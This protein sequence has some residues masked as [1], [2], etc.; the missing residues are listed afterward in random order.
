MP[1]TYARLMLRQWGTTPERAAALQMQGEP[2]KQAVVDI[3]DQFRQLTVLDRLL[4][5]GWGLQ[6][7]A[8]FDA[9]SH[10]QVGVAM[11]CAPNF[12]EALSVA[13]RFGH[14]R[15]PF[16]RYEFRVRG[17]YCDLVMHDTGLLEHTMSVPLFDASLVG[18]QNLLKK[19][20]GASFSGV[21]FE[22]RNERPSYAAR[23]DDYLDA[24]V[25]FGAAETR[26]AMPVEWLDKS[27]PFSDVDMYES[28]IRQLEEIER[29]KGIED[30]LVGSVMLLV[31]VN[32]CRFPTL[33]EVA[34]RLHLS[35][36]TL[37]RRLH[38]AG[39]SYRD[40]CDRYRRERAIV[41]LRDRKIGIADVG[42]R[43][44]Y[45]DSANFGR[46]CRRWFGASPR[47]VRHDLSHNAG[48]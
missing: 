47:Q 16:L 27:S 30:P 18:I 42:Y 20:V 31:S 14:L 24:P 34:E 1:A 9:T 25:R 28:A 45:A 13:A 40:L 15:T 2:S 37:I 19:I 3:R 32:D 12:R 48:N 36:R 33:E 23:Y 35:N 11:T 7:G 38:D 44:G 17:R 41:L 26:L 43:L 10:G 6:L 4:S 29:K 5:P 21:I 39:T 46:A 22:V 8:L